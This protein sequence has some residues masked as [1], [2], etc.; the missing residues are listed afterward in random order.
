VRITGNGFLNGVAVTMMDPQ[1]TAR[2]VAGTDILSV[3]PTVITAN[4][5]LN[6]AGSWR[7][8]VTNPGSVQSSFFVFTVFGPPAVTSTDPAVPDHH[9]TDE[10]QFSFVGTGFMSGL[11]VNLTAPPAAPGGAAPAPF[12][13]RVISVTV[14]TVKVA[15]V[16]V[17]DGDWHAVV[18]NP[19]NHAS[20]TYSFHVN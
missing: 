19:G 2:A 4:L 16:L 6:M 14:T 9:A 12:A 5:P 15:A 13:A 17:R 20:N 11:T 3:D 10:K 1:R 7:V 8:A 18:T